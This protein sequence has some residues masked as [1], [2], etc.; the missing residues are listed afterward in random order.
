[1]KPTSRRAFL[2]ST[3]LALVVGALGPQASALQERDRSAMEAS[4][5]V[6]QWYAIVVES[7]KTTGGAEV[8]GW[9][10]AIVAD[11]ANEYNGLVKIKHSLIEALRAGETAEIKANIDGIEPQV[12]QLIQ[13]LERL[14]GHL[15]HAG[16][17]L[18]E[19]T[20]QKIRNGL[21]ERAGWVASAKRELAKDE[22][23]FSLVLEEGEDALDHIWK[24]QVKLWTLLGGL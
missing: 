6:V 4:D 9:A 19:E 11:F 8:R 3:M 20:E 16:G 14:G 23:D 24:A 5:A 17:S 13:T 18:M 22:P 12:N 2:I 7:L 21:S 1:M 15:P 10:I